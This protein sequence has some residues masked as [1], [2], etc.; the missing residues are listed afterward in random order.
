MK[1]TTSCWTADKWSS[2]DF[3]LAGVAGQI[4]GV[5]V[6]SGTPAYMAPEQL[7]GKEVTTRSDI[8]ALGLV[9]YEIFTGKRA[10]TDAAASTRKSGKADNLLSRPSSVVKDIDPAVERAIMRCLETDP[11]ARPANMLSVAAALP[12]GD[13]LAAALAAEKPLP[14]NWSPHRAKPLA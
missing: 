11:T 6:R 14:Q 1:L 5:E 7:A 2:L 12:G 10:F 8:Y 9:L 13:P 4:Q 3:G